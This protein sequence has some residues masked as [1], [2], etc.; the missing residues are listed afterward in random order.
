MEKMTFH[1]PIGDIPAERVEEMLE[2]L[3]KTLNIPVNKSY[4]NKN[5]GD[6]AEYDQ[7][8]SLWYVKGKEERPYA[9][10]E[11]KNSD[12]WDPAVELIFPEEEKKP[13]FFSRLLR[14][15]KLKR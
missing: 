1:I 8:M 6:V 13:S 7:F 4:I 12:E 10:H 5:N 14:K 11:L 9:S 15:L 3:R 2:E